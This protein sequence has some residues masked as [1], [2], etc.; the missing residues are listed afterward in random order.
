M[1]KQQTPQKILIDILKGCNPIATMFVFDAISKHTDRILSDQE[2]T[3]DAMKNSFI[4]GEA[5]VDAAKQLQVAFG[6]SK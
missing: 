4:D 1:K 5:W 3:I 6:W 2:Q